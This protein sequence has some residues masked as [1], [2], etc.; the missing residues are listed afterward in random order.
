MK[1]I[2]PRRLGDLAV[3]A[4]STAAKVSIYASD[5]RVLLAAREYVLQARAEDLPGEAAATLQLLARNVRKTSSQIQINPADLRRLLGL[6]SEADAHEKAAE[7][8][9]EADVSAVKASGARQIKANGQPALVGPDHASARASVRAYAFDT[10]H[11]AS[12]LGLHAET[13]RAA[14]RRGD[15]VPTDLHSIEAYKQRTQK[16]RRDGE[17]EQVD[18]EIGGMKLTISKGGKP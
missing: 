12:F 1:P 7:R 15:L 3:L 13:V 10:D 8:E 6:Y 4:D 16:V 14:I 17:P 5:A 9:Q 18:V 11:L 2:N